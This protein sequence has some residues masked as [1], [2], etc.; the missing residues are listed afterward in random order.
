[1]EPAG[2]QWIDRRAALIG[3]AALAAGA[4]FYALARPPGSAYL[5]PFDSSVPVAVSWFGAYGAWLPSFIHVFAFSLLSAALL[6]RTRIAAAGSC[7]TWWAVNSLFEL[8]QHPVFARPVAEAMPAWF[9]G[10]YVLEN[11][12]AFFLH[13]SFD[14]ADLTAAAGGALCAYAALVARGARRPR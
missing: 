2:N 13:G 4:A 5:L 11:S 14:Y 8:G 7:A 6:P 3:A 12:L 1:M 10:L 9:E